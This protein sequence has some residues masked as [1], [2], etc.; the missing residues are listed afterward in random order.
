MKGDLRIAVDVSNTI[1]TSQSSSPKTWY[2][3]LL[4]FYH[5]HSRSTFLTVLTVENG[6]FA[7]FEVF[8]KKEALTG[9]RIIQID[10]MLN[11]S[12]IVFVRVTTVD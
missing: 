2:N 3:V 11:V 7:L 6:N 10:S 9:R 5:L 12:S 1:S 4:L 8:F